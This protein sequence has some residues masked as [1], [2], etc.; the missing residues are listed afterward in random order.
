MYSPLSKAFV[1][2]S[3]LLNWALS[4]PIASPEPE[5]S[6]HQNLAQRSIK[7][8]TLIKRSDDQPGKRQLADVVQVYPGALNIHTSALPFV[9]L[10]EN[11]Y[12]IFSQTDGSINVMH[13][14]DDTDVE[15]LGSVQ[16][17]EA[18]DCLDYVCTLEFTSGGDL[19][20]KNGQVS[21]HTATAGE[22]LVFSD[23]DPWIVILDQIGDTIWSIDT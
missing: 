7:V 14:I 5:A 16:F 12:F 20:F 3:L 8:D 1:L 2:A 18:A 22:L 6:A 19:V 23:E 9:T 15:V 13:E 11:I 17:G 21:L 4:V 10:L